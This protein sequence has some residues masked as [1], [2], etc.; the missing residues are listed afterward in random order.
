M[1]K[2]NKILHKN[3]KIF[4]NA[5]IILCCYSSLVCAE[6]NFLEVGGQF[7]RSKPGSVLDAK[8]KTI[9]KADSYGFFIGAGSYVTSD[10]A[11]G[12]NLKHLNRM[13]GKSETTVTSKRGSF[14]NSHSAY[15]SSTI[16][17]ADL[18]YD[19]N[20]LKILGIVPYA[21]LGG[22]LAFHSVVLDQFI[23]GSNFYGKKVNSTSGILK[24]G[25]GVT[26]QV[27]E[28]TFIS[29]GYEKLISGKIKYTDE[30]GDRKA[31]M[32]ADSLVFSTS[33]KF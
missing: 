16:F 31:R 9:S 25:V 11:F 30:A 22:G 1:K 26:K 32:K 3:T 27:T 7:V 19:L 21:K 18:T 28:K 13:K 8:N 6:G 10:L 2:I 33:F 4:R 5:S 23:S 24:L 12:L 29:L 17:S 14:S 20:K 15:I